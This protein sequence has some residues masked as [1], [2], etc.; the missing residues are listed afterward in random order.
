M[1]TPF[2]FDG[3][4]EQLI[5]VKV[6]FTP[7]YAQ[8]KIELLLSFALRP[9]CFAKSAV[10]LCH[11]QVALTINSMALFYGLCG[12]ISEDLVAPPLRNIQ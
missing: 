5:A 2:I 7:E 12:S 10:S 4:G 11:M 9:F 8:T 1:V 3:H 6:F